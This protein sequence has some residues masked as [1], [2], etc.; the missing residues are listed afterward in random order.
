MPSTNG[1]LLRFQSLV[2]VELVLKEI[3]ASL[4][5]VEMVG[6]APRGLRCQAQSDGEGGGSAFAIAMVQRI[7][8]PAALSTIPHVVGDDF[9]IAIS[10]TNVLRRMQIA[11]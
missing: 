1:G 4:E 11:H 3:T 7:A 2:M 6:R 10:Q 8:T 9:G 5:S